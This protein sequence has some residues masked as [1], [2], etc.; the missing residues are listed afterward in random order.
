MRH[1]LPLGP[2]LLVV[3]VLLINVGAHRWGGAW[4]LTAERSATLSP[5]TREVLRALE[6]RV[7]V[8]AFIE[9]D[10]PGRVEAATLL[11]RY[12]RINRRVSFRILDPQLAPVEL[13]RLS[14]SPGSVAVEAV[15]GERSVEVAP[16]PNEIDVTSAIARIVRQVT[17]TL[18]FTSGH[19]ERSPNDGTAAGLSTVARLLVENGYR[20]STVDLLVQAAVPPVCDAVVVAAP[21][22]QPSEPVVRAVVDHLRAGRGALLLSDPDAAAD[23]SP[24]AQ[25]WG[26]AFA[27]GVVLE[28]DPGSRL[29]GDPY[30]PVVA[31]YSSGGPV[32]PGLGPTFYPRVGPVTVEGEPGRAGLSAFPVAQTSPRSTVEHDGADAGMRGPIVVGAAADES[33]VRA[34]GVRRTRLVAW[35]DVDFASNRYVGE[36]AN[37]VLVLR[38][39]DWLTQ[40]EPLLAAAPNLPRLR[41]LDLTEARRR[42]MLYL[43]TVFVPGLFLLA[44]ALT[45]VVRR[46]R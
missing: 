37:A 45:W 2:L 14:A 44:G 30:S 19:G 23:L 34:E 43:T 46:S 5:A 16:H 17:S 1:R 15:G 25:P 38:A 42:Y 12:R 7:M 10:A 6:R 27:P 21:T 40:P 18:C 8:T 20:L 4:D 24:L 22:N 41:E 35:G 26:M 11:S 29:L 28:Q 33:E 3:A 32:P 13:Q 39:V 31:R 9:R 36:G